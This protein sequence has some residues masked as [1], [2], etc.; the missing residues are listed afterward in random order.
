MDVKQDQSASIEF[1]SKHWHYESSREIAYFENEGS[2]SEGLYRWLFREQ[3]G[4]RLVC[5]EKWE[6]ETF[7]CPDRPPA[8]ETGHH[9]RVPR[10]L[11]SGSLMER[12]SPWSLLRLFLIGLMVLVATGGDWMICPAPC[13]S[14]WTPQAANLRP[15][16]RLTKRIATR[17]SA[18][19]RDE[20]PLCSR[21]RP[22]SGAPRLT[23][24]APAWMRRRPRWP[25]SSSLSMP[26][27]AW[28]PTRPAAFLTEF[29]TARAEATRDAA[30]LRADADRW[31][32]QKRALPRRLEAMRASYD[33]VRTFDVDAA[34][35]PVRKAMIDWPDKRDD[36]EKRLNGI[37]GT[38]NRGPA[39]W[40]SSAPR[41]EAAAAGKLGQF[42]LQ[43]SV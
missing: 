11:R 37:Q 8:R 15:I 31:L 24:A 2:A 41:R 19:L 22:R 3:D 4:S 5:V 33:A 23:A 34:T 1:E 29:N 12:R 28:T 35:V 43:D 6:G 39:D 36:L 10:R 18:A 13:G 7:R 38:W 25:R 42:R 26:I 21:T 40:D 14:R 9:R 32:A 16:A 17:S 20:S 27:A 30:E